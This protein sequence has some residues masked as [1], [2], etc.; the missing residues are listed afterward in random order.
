MPSLE[1]LLLFIVTALVIHISPGPSN[2]YVLSRS[3]SQ[4]S[5]AGFAAAAGL[6]LGGAVYVAAAALGLSVLFQVSA[7]AYW[8]LKIVGA[9]YLIW[10]GIGAWRDALR[11]DGTAGPVAPLARDSRW[12]IFRQ[13]VLVEVLNP[14]SALFYLAFLPQFVDPAVGSVTLQLLV[15]GALSVLLAVPCDG[16]VALAAGQVARLLARRPLFTRVQ[17]GVS[18]TILIGLGAAMALSRRA[19]G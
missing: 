11:R 4:G 10:L 17:H 1:T 19:G 2:L 7:T 18:G 14:K 16:A 3:I 15:L 13:S 9:G 5:G 6:A 8:T 12:R